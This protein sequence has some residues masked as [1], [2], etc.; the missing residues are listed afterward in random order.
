MNEPIKGVPLESQRKC[1]SCGKWTWFFPWDK[2]K[3]C[4]ICEKMEN[5]KR[6][7]A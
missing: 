1:K 3:F 4:D 5:H 6:D 2:S 7:Y